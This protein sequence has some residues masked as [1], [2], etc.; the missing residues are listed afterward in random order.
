MMKIFSDV[1][2]LA[3]LAVLVAMM[4]TANAFSPPTPTSQRFSSALQMGL[5]DGLKN[6]FAN[7]EVRFFYVSFLWGRT[8][9]PNL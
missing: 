8:A 9:C 7:E 6:A 4:T 3:L 1:P 2:S 5:F